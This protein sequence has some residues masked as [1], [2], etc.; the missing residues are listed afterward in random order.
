MNV[1]IRH[2]R[3]NTVVIKL[4]LRL[5]DIE[6]ESLRKWLIQ[7]DLMPEADAIDEWVRDNPF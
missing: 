4:H 6:L 1:T 5:L 2:D 3:P 7:N